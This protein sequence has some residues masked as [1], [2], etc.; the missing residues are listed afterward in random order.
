M[1]LKPSILSPKV[2][3]IVAMSLARTPPTWDKL[4]TYLRIKK[5]FGITESV[6]FKEADKMGVGEKCILAEQTGNLRV[7]CEQ[8]YTVDLDAGDREQLRTI[9]QS[10]LEIFNA[11]TDVEALIELDTFLESTEKVSPIQG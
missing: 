10:S 4:M 3:R 5:A 11:G 1:A 7:L 2:R 6:P 9:V 8:P